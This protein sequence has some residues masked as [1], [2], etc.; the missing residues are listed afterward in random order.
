MSAQEQTL[1]ERADFARLV[2]VI[3]LDDVRQ[4]YRRSGAAPRA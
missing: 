2:G 3:S 4:A 1:T